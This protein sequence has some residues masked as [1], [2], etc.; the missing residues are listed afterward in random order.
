MFS[1]LW[2]EFIGGR[3]AVGLLFMRLI[4]GF[5]LIQHG[6]PKI[7]HA[8][9]WMP[10]EMGMPGSLQALAALAEFGG[11]LALMLGLLT[12]IACFGIACTMGV[13]LLTVHLPHGDP[14]VGATGKASYEAALTYFAVGVMYIFTG[15]GTFALDAIFFR[16]KEKAPTSL[17][18]TPLGHISGILRV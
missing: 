13:A 2:P 5:A 4:S 8:F 7:Q 1:L 11:G 12:P 14:M 10:A 18:S 17:R 9:N 6:W 16:E 3:G 15:P